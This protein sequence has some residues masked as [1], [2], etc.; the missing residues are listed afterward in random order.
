[1]VTATLTVDYLD[2]GPSEHPPR[3]T[4]DILFEL[5]ETDQRYEVLDGK[6]VMSPA[7]TPGHSAALDE[8]GWLFRT[9]LPPRL[10]FLQGA[11]VRLP[12][13]DGPIPDLLITSA[14]DVIKLGNTMPTD[15][16]HTVVEV[17]SPSNAPTGRDTKTRLY[18]EAGIPCYWRIEQR[19]WREHRGPVP[20]V[21][22][23]LRDKAGD[24]RQTLAAAG[25][26]SELPTQRR[27]LSS[28]IGWSPRDRS[29]PGAHAARLLSSGSCGC[30]S[31]RCR[32]TAGI[33]RTPWSCYRTATAR[34]RI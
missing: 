26:T 15:L 33:C 30:S 6:L 12:N 32:R 14:P 34:S 19:R 17:V 1:V 23:R 13:G 31:A 29:T 2:V 11:A 5:P 7:P 22:V 25:A 21:V 18:A 9:Q 27:K 20:A 3:L 16:V 28:G 10:R 24:W 8:L 4:V